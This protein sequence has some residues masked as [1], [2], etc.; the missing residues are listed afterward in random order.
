M[1]K[2]TL[3]IFKIIDHKIINK[4]YFGS[5]KFNCFINFQI[6]QKFCFSYL[7][8]YWTIYYFWFIRINH[9]K[10]NQNILDFVLVCRFHVCCF[11]NRWRNVN[12]AKKKCLVTNLPWQKKFA[13]N[14]K[15]SQTFYKPFLSCTINGKKD[16]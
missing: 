10:I 3:F 13:N 9:T 15:N 2:K 7:I 4:I 5:A 8:Y 11:I 1:L 6:L 12:K 14:L 16:I